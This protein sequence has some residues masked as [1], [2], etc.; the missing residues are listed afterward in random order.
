MSQPRGTNN[1]FFP[2]IEFVPPISEDPNADTYSVVGIDNTTR[3]VTPTLDGY[4]INEING[5]RANANVTDLKVVK[6]GTNV[7][8][9]GHP[10]FL[11]YMTYGLIEKPGSAP[12][13]RNYL[14]AGTISRGLIYYVSINSAVS[15]REFTTVL[16]PQVLQMI[17]S[18]QLVQQ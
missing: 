3:S 4:T 1:T 17:K 8:I 6:A 15:D 10:G 5:F 13:P 14:E 16:L 7:T 2:I 11:L 12:T 18:F 9:G